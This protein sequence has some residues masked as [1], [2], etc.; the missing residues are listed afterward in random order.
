MEATC[1]SEMSADNKPTWRHIPEA[2]ILHNHRRETI[3]SYIWLNSTMWSHDTP[4]VNCTGTWIDWELHH[5]RVWGVEDE[6]GAMLTSFFHQLLYSQGKNNSAHATG[7]LASITDS[8]TYI[9]TYVRPAQLVSQESN[10]WTAC[11]IWGFQGD[12]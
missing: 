3:K 4:A 12:D 1:Y 8:Y 5:E 7:T 11:G 2:I 10:D 6:L 9:H